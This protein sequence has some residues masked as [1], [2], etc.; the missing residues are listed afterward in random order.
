M[1]LQVKAGDVLDPNARVRE[2]FRAK[3][4]GHFRRLGPNRWDDYVL[5]DED[6]GEMDVLPG[7]RVQLEDQGAEVRIRSHGHVLRVR[8]TTWMS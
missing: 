8:D 7:V 2:R 5:V 1:T 3:I 4:V 6:Q